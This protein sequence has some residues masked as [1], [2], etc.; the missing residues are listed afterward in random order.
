MDLC[1][2]SNTILNAK[3][4]A[5]EEYKLK[6]TI[7]FEKKA[8]VD[9]WKVLTTVRI[10]PK[11]TKSIWKISFVDLARGEGTSQE[12]GGK[13]KILER[14]WDESDSFTLMKKCRVWILRISNL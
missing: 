9:Q 3:L 6:T 1:S 5:F 8:F 12:F 10:V 2:C 14:V 11:T 13:K 4:H 7:V